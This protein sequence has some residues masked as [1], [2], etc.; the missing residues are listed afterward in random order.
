MTL[1]YSLTE[2]RIMYDL[3]WFQLLSL[4][5]SS[6]H[7][8]PVETTKQSKYF[9]PKNSFLKL[10]W[11]LL[12]G[13]HVWV[14]YFMSPFLSQKWHH[15][16]HISPSK[17]CMKDGKEMIWIHLKGKKM[18]W[19]WEWYLIKIFLLDYTPLLFS[20]MSDLA[21]M[22]LFWILPVIKWFSTK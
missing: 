3:W 19:I 22:V 9:I 14:P 15:F 6:S 20:G 13:Y 7:M 8:Y 2:L 12:Q 1:Y 10:L 4:S 18:G 16:S 5:C 11:S 21:N 17:I